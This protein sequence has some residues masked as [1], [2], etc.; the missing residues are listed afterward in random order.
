MSTASSL[1]VKHMTAARAMAAEAES[2]AAA[3]P[4]SMYEGID[5][6]FSPKFR[7]GPAGIEAE[8]RFKAA[9]NIVQ[10]TVDYEQ[11]ETDWDTTAVVDE[12]E[13]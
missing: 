6:V 1:S 5:M 12:D 11:E 8:K 10:N 13:L 9:A 7:K 2:A 4:E 3:N